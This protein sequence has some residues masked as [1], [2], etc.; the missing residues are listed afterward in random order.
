MY[1]L[2][3]AALFSINAET[4]HDVT[5]SALKFSN[6]GPIGRFAKSR[7]PDAPVS[8]MGIDF[9]NPV[10]L[11]A[12]LDKDGAYIDG[13]AN[14]GFGFIEIGTVTPRPQDGN[15]KPR[16]FRLPQRDAIINRMGFNNAGVDALVKN[17]ERTSFNGVL[18][19]NI[20][21]NRDTPANLAVNDYIHCLRAVYALAT[22]VTV[23]VSSPNTPGLRD[24][25]HGQALKD[26]FDALKN[27]QAALNQTNNRYVPVAI[28]IAPDL[29]DEEIDEIA[30]AV[31]EFK[32]DAVI[33]TNTTNDR[34]DVE[35]LAFA[36][37][38]GG[39]SG[40]PLGNKSTDVV[41]QL[42]KTLS[43]HTP[44]IA[45]GGIMRAAD[46]TAKIAAGAQLIQLYS[47][48]IY[49]GPRLIRECVQ[50]MQ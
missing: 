21:K 32:V 7:V 37:E 11:C 38:T 10:G 9:P 8:V 26:L 48:L 35:G 47:G 36:E 15:P 20:G 39:L 40:A 33:A 5:L 13:L 18:G 12:G 6:R 34:S 29:I 4:A 43:G 41:R 25:Q 17:V 31:R 14:L 50:A 19:I 1:S 42:A 30:A 49:R 16:I 23:N 22:Y 44:I 3:R 28:K 24:L 2:L 46:A 27:E 45:A